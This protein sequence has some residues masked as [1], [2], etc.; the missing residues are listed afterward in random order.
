[1]NKIDE[2][3]VKLC[4]HGV[5]LREIG[6]LLE[7]TTN[8]RWQDA[9]E[10]I[11][12]YIDLTSVDRNTHKIGNTEIVNSKSAPS[13]AQQIVL[14]GDVIFGTT[15][16]LLRRYSLVS[17][18]YDGQICSTGYC[19]LRPNK[20]LLLPKFLFHLLGENSFYEYVE[21]N[22]RGA[23]YPAIADRAVKAFRIPAPPIEVQAEIA[24]VLD[25]FTELE[26]ELHAELDAR[27][28]QYAYYRDTLLSFDKHSRVQWAPLG[29]VTTIVRGASPRPIQ[30]FVTNSESGIP[31]IKI[32]DV[33]TDGKYITKTAQRVT[34][35]GA[36]K[37]RRVYPGDFLLS[38]SMSF[39]RP[40]ITK[41]EGC[42]HDGWLSISSFKDSFLPDFLYHLLR[43]TPIQQEF[44]RR[45]G[46]GVVQNLNAD[47]VR[48]VSVPIPTLEEQARISNLLDKFETLLNDPAIG[49]PAEIKARRQQYEHYRS[50]LLTF[51]E[52]T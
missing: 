19:V 8:I 45:A 39:G 38:N 41:I 28:K 11:F 30:S 27:R 52:A 18:E 35:A 31:W 51:K 22:Q 21:A 29:E 13:R 10:E 26:T 4:P 7:K 5:Q 9:E 47:I 15:R 32:G 40:Y 3:I 43:S 23:A 25:K 37:S 14:E 49:L 17:A 20:K 16:P 36:E 44:Y 2:L 48:S 1:M 24:Q 6:Q 50:R 33:P 34:P 42:I 46:A 12:R